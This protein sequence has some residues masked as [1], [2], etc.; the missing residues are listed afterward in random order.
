MFR[1]TKFCS[2]SFALVFFPFFLRA[3]FFELLLSTSSMSCSDQESKLELLPK[4]LISKNNFKM[5]VNNDKRNSGKLRELRSRVGPKIARLQ[6]RTLDHGAIG[7]SRGLS[8]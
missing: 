1:F 4:K 7:G 5:L 6:V 3:V 2:F 8:Q